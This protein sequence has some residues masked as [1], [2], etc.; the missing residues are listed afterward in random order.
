MFTSYFG[1]AGSLENTVSIARGNPKAYRG[2]S[3]KLVAPT[4]A[5]IRN[6]KE[7]EYR[8]A[9]A[10]ILSGLSPE[11]VYDDIV[12]LAGRE[13]ILLCWEKPGV[14]CHRRLLAEWLEERLGIEI[15][16]MPIDSDPLLF[17]I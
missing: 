8:K 4:W 9:Y 6:M 13:A 10:E 5:M 1:Y 7:A 14:F 2:K 3:Y 11:R 15:R 16:E 17:N 12:T